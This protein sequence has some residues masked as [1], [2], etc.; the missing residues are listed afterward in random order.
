ML[1]M[2]PCVADCHHVYQARL[3]VLLSQGT[4]ASDVILGFALGLAWIICNW[5]LQ[6]SRGHSVAPSQQGGADP[7]EGHL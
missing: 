3:Q 2:P 7:M 6:A 1:P 5:W 4:T